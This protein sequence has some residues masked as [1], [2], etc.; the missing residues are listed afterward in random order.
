MDPAIYSMCGTD[1]TLLCDEI[2]DGFSLPTF[3]MMVSVQIRRKDAGVDRVR[4]LSFAVLC[5]PSVFTYRVYGYKYAY[6][7]F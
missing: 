3:G 5:A 4:L 2:G 7:C 6:L 1:M